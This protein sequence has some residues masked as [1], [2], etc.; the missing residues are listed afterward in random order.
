MALEETYFFY[1][2]KSRIIIENL[3]T[4]ITI[5][6]EKSDTNILTTGIN[7][8]SP[9]SPVNNASYGHWWYI[10]LL[11]LAFSIGPCSLNY[12][13]KYVKQRVSSI[14]LPLLRGQYNPQ[15]KMNP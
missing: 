8:C 12:L 5:R 15:R 11:L 14:K 7:P 1:V 9:V 13:L 10:N 6:K 4:E 2:L 3:V